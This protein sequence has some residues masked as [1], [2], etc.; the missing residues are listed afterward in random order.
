MK[1]I[2]GWTSTSTVTGATARRDRS[3]GQRRT[4]RIAAAAV[5]ALLASAL[6]PGTMAPA[7]AAVV[8]APPATNGFPASFDDGNVK[9]GLGP[10]ADG[11]GFYFS[12]SATGGKLQLYEAALEA[13]YTT[14]PVATP[15]QEIVFS[16]L[17]F[18][19]SA[20]M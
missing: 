4:G 7:S 11:E 8:S 9:L 12:A 5:T 17:R 19:M 10:L 13:T 15:G 1:A 6:A 2:I 3:A 18:R 14:A 20:W 16:R